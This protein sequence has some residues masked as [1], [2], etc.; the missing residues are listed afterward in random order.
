[1][2]SKVILLL[3]LLLAVI[4]A[5]AVYLAE[6]EETAEKQVEPTAGEME[7]IQS[8]EYAPEIKDEKTTEST[9]F[10]DPEEQSQ[11]TESAAENPDQKVKDPKPEINEEQNESKAGEEKTSAK[12]TD[13]ATRKEQGNVTEKEELPEVSIE[14]ENVEADDENTDDESSTEQ[15]EEQSAAQGKQ[16]LDSNELPPVP[17]F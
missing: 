14:F 7:Q 10:A 9:V 15:Q 12:N 13:Q 3:C 2:K 1:M 11:Q 17:L 6:P 16:K 8:E 5:V 4:T